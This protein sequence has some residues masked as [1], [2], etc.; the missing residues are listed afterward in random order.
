MVCFSLSSKALLQAC[1]FL[2]HILRRTRPR[3][4]GVAAARFERKTTKQN[5]RDKPGHCIP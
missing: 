1:F 3:H 2:R 4:N 5:G